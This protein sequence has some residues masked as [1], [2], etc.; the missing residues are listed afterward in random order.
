MSGGYISCGEFIGDDKSGSALEGVLNGIIT[1]LP[2]GEKAAFRE[3]VAAPVFIAMR[4]CGEQ[5][6]ISPDAVSYLFDPLVRYHAYLSE[7]LGNPEPFL[8]PELDRQ[9]GLDLTAAKYG[10][11]QGWQFYCTH[12]LLKACEISRQTGEPIVISFD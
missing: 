5:F 6:E 8:A 2:D 3:R 1:T 11:G 7:L 10:E 9:R 4:R 12:D